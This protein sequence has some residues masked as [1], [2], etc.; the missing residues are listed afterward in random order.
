MWS[1]P[2]P[3][4]LERNLAELANGARVTAPRASGKPTPSAGHLQP[5][6]QS[7]AQAGEAGQQETDRMTNHLRGHRAARAI[8]AAM[9]FQWEGAIEPVVS[10]SERDAAL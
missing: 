5:Q 6:G 3:P 10:E 7:C 2:R 4:R 1:I 8:A 9:L